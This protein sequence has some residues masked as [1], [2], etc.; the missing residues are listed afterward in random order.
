VQPGLNPGEDDDAF[1]FLL[2]LFFL[3]NIGEGGLEEEL[4]VKLHSDCF[5]SIMFVHNDIGVWMCHKDEATSS[6]ASDEELAAKFLVL[7]GLGFDDKVYQSTIGIIPEVY[8]GNEQRLADLL[9]FGHQLSEQE[10]AKVQAYSLIASAYSGKMYVV[11]EGDPTATQILNLVNEGS[12]SCTDMFKGG[13]SLLT[14]CCS[15]ARANHGEEGARVVQALI[16][17]AGELTEEE[18]QANGNTQAAQEQ[19]RLKFVNHVTREGACALHRAVHNQKFELVKVLVEAGADIGL[20]SNDSH[21]AHS[22]ALLYGKGEASDRQEVATLFVDMCDLIEQRFAKWEVVEEA[23]KKGSAAGTGV[24]SDVV[25]LVASLTK[26]IGWSPDRSLDKLQLNNHLGPLRGT[27][28]EFQHELAPKIMLVVEELCLPLLTLAG[29][30]ELVDQDDSNGSTAG[31]EPRLKLKAFCRD[32]LNAGVL[33]I[34]TP[35]GWKWRDGSEATME[36]RVMLVVQEGMGKLEA[37]LQAFYEAARPELAVLPHITD[38]EQLVGDAIPWA[39]SALGGSSGGAGGGAGAILMHQLCAHGREEIRWLE[40][41]DDRAAVN[42]LLRTGMSVREVML[43]SSGLPT[44]FGG[45]D[46][47]TFRGF[48]TSVYMWWLRAV[49]TRCDAL[50]Q[51]WIVAV[52]ADTESDWVAAGAG[53][54]GGLE[55]QPAPLKTAARVSDKK[56][57]YRQDTVDLMRAAGSG[58]GVQAWAQRVERLRDQ[59]LTLQTD[60]NAS[61]KDARSHEHEKTKGRDWI[62][63]ELTKR[64][65]WSER[66]AEHIPALGHLLEAG[67]MGDFCRCSV[68]CDSPR[69]LRDVYEKL[70]AMRLSKGDVGE[71]VRV[72]NGFHKDAISS[73]GY[74][75]IKLNILVD[76]PLPGGGSVR[77]IAEVQLLLAHYVEVKKHMH[78]LYKV[79][80][81]DFF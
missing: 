58:K 78:L 24:D 41:L 76:V 17:K 73:G 46:P 65:V 66:G 81:G 4:D 61:F 54:T 42:A 31:G 11:N 59:G 33:T 77:H 5:A 43:L 9:G 67:G 19:K 21:T 1:F 32:V 16:E 13:Q 14:I 23:I 39:D 12:L 47:K 62:V 36:E 48:W 74:R 63:Q 50:L 7:Y 55:H 56:A 10:K 52:L 45:A 79:Q 80:R 51:P 69:H 25:E 20:R 8:S 3:P 35:A 68:S 22:F 72:K 15:K 6:T 26:D 29:D 34:Q 70:M 64:G 2:K 27:S 60:T 40:E 38:A 71:V 75:D 44:L 30:K 37:E 49:A 28:S 57:D 18:M 53:G